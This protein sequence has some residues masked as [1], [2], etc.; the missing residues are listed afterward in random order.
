MS[1]SEARNALEWARLGTALDRKCRHR[2]P[3]PRNT[4]LQLIALGAA[5]CRESGVSPLA[6]L[7]DEKAA[8]H[9]R[10]PKRF[11]HHQP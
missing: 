8:H 10:T 1:P 3:Y 6:Y 5:L 9:A 2:D 4:R 11:A 7:P